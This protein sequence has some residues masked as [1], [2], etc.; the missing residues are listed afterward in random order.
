[1]KIPPPN[2]AEH[3]QT[4]PNDNPPARRFPRLSQPPTATPACH[5]HPQPPPPVA[6]VRGCG[7]LWSAV[8]GCG[9]LWTAV[10]GCVPLG[11]GSRRGGDLKKS[12]TKN[13]QGINNFS[14]PL[15]SGASVSASKP[16]SRFGCFSYAPGSAPTFKWN[17]RYN[18]LGL[19]N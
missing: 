18:G 15:L 4:P 8:D 2:T 5:S 9:R 11:V 13:I 16:Q 14:C 12:T 17:A 6:A 10:G 19:F 3:R 1:M 7:R